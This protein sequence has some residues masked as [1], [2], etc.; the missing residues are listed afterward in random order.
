G[1]LFYLIPALLLALAIAGL[2]GVAFQR[3]FAEFQP[4]GVEL[5][6]VGSVYMVTEGA[7]PPS[8]DGLLAGDM[9]F[10]V[11]G[12]LPASLEAVEARLRSVKTAPVTVKRGDTAVKTVTYQRPSIDI[13]PVYLTLATVGVFYL[14]IGLYTCLRGQHAALFVLWC[15]A[16]AAFYLLSPR[17]P[18]VDATDR[19]IFFADQLARSLLPALT[20]HLFLVFPQ[21]LFQRRR[22]AWALP[23]LYLAPLGSIAFHADQV[24]WGGSQL[25]GAATAAQVAAVDRLELI[26]L[27]GCALVSA[28]VVA[29][30]LGRNLGW[31]Q[32][33]QMQ[34]MLAGMVGG[35]V[36]FLF[37]YL[38]P[39]SLG[40]TTPLWSTLVAVA[41]L[42]LVPL[43]FA[44]AIFKYKLLDLSLILRDAVAYSAAAV[45]GLFGFYVVRILVEQGVGSGFP[46]SRAVMT[47]AAGLAV[48]SVLAP[49]KN[50][51]ST[52][53]ERWQH[54]GLWGRRSLLRSLGGELLHERD[55][56][57]L[58]RRLTEQLSDTFVV[59]ASLYFS[60][61]DGTMQA[62]EPRDNYPERLDLDALG[63]GVWKRDVEAI[64]GV[65]LPLAETTQEQRLFAVGFRYAFPV[66]VQGHPIGLLLV[67]Y[68]YDEEPLD[69]E[70]LELIRG[71]LNQAALAIENARLF[72]EVRHQLAE[73]SRLEA[74]NQ[75][76][77]QSSP[78]G[79]AVLDEAQRVVSANPAFHALIGA[80]AAVEGQ[81]LESLLPVRPLPDLGAGPV[82]VAYCEPSG[83]ERY[84]QVSLAGYQAAA[85]GRQVLVAQDVTGRV[86]MEHELREKE[87]LASLGMLAAG[88]AHEVNTP[89]TG[90]SSYAQFLLDDTEPGDPRYKILQKME[91][92]TFRASQIVNNLLDFARNRRGE[93]NRVNLGAAITEAVQLL[94]LRATKAGVAVEWQVPAEATTVL[95]NEG[96]LHQVIT[97]LLTN[98]FDAVS[99]HSGE[100]RVEVSVQERGNRYEVAVRDSGPGIPEERLNSIF[101]P[102]FSSKLGRGGS[103]LGLAITYNIVRRHGGEIVARNP[104]GGGACFTVTLPAYA[105]VAR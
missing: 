38:T 105:A 6:R 65:G 20:L 13:D 23:L 101:K 78:A 70:D 43:A 98:A 86:T 47:F 51:V 15:L 54:R 34:W 68:K 37:F 53:L 1:R 3:T 26:L 66:A 71:L 76:I 28:A 9:I 27:V 81:A 73:V 88:V 72:G 19:L 97:N 82:E 92:Q 59:R 74:Y 57:Q 100:R 36:P 25:F 99:T 75:G 44:Y 7:E 56:D 50:A 24:F 18:P 31:E 52:S 95:G 93:M 94:D 29:L 41:P 102:F 80:E 11:A 61:G 69:G 96:E 40:W 58:C 49:T 39:Y 104:D 55:L 90:I 77:L 62:F 45:V 21:P 12:E 14:L 2:G 84:L 4:L 35:Y 17:L 79:I 60:A 48:A 103:G 89:L 85:V 32:K 63:S 46:V 30:R 33:R 5:T 91:R 64:S 42:A 22:L 16:S 10:S 67:S 8:E 87:H 83:Q